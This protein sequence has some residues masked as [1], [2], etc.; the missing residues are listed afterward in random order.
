MIRLAERIRTN[1]G[2][3][4]H[5]KPNVENADYQTDNILLKGLVDNLYQLEDSLRMTDAHLA[6]KK[7]SLRVE[8][9]EILIVSVNKYM[10]LDTLKI[11]SK[12][13]RNQQ[14]FSRIRQ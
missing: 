3:L 11:F 10:R 5:D 4:K 8:G 6:T 14:R 1:L 12:C 13:P 9:F 2:V 7:I